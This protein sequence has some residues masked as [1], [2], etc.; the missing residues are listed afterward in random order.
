MVDWI[1]PQPQLQ[2]PLRRLALTAA[3]LRVL[4]GL[5]VLEILSAWAGRPWPWERALR[6]ATWTA[7][8]L[9]YAAWAL[10]RAALIQRLRRFGRD[11]P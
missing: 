7:L 6:W 10:Q 5:A 1:D 11:Q 4:A 3:A 2:G 8:L 9:V